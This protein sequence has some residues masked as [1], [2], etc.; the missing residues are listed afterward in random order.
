VKIQQLLIPAV[1]ASILAFV[2]RDAFAHP[3]HDHD[4]DKPTGMRRWT[5]AKGPLQLDA[6]FVAALDG[7]VQCG[8]GEDDRRPPPR[9]GENPPPRDGKRPPPRNEEPAASKPRSDLP[10]LEVTSAALDANGF[11]SAEFTCDGASASPPVAW[12]GAPEG[13][14]SF[15]LSLWHT[16]PDQEKSYWVVYNIPVNT[17]KVAK[18]AKNIGAIGRNDKRRAEYDPMCSKGP[19]VKTYHITVYALSSELKL[20]PDQATRANL[21]AAIKGITVAEGTLDFKYERKK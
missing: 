7:Q 11:I 14:K 15:A 5:E 4:D 16:A 12:K 20:S 8:S 21:L 6:S 10:Q 2:V 1:C 13:T 17:T 9:P 18:N 19:G 3:G